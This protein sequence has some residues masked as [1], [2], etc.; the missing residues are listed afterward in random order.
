[1]NLNL[2]D[3]QWYNLLCGYQ[4]G[5]R[6]SNPEGP[7]YSENNTLLYPVSTKTGVIGIMGAGE[8]FKIDNPYIRVAFQARYINI[9]YNGFSVA[10]Q[11]NTSQLSLVGIEPGHF[12]TVGGP[13][14]SAEVRY[15]ESGGV[16]HVLGK[17][18]E[19]RQ[20]IYSSM[21]AVVYDDN[22]KIYSTGYKGTDL[23]EVLFYLVFKRS[24]LTQ[25][26]YKLNIE[27]TTPTDLNGT[28][29]FQVVIDKDEEG[30]ETERIL[31][32]YPTDNEQVVNLT[33]KETKPVQIVKP[34]GPILTLG[35]PS[36]SSSTKLDTGAYFS[37]TWCEVGKDGDLSLSIINPPN[38]ELKYIK[39][40]LDIPD[41]TGA[42]VFEE[43]SGLT[44]WSLQG[45]DSYSNI[46]HS[47]TLQIIGEAD[48]TASQ[49]NSPNVLRFSILEGK[50]GYSQIKLNPSYVA[51]DSYPFSFKT[52][53]MLGVEFGAG[54]AGQIK[55]NT[56]TR[57]GVTPNGKDYE[58]VITTLEGSALPPGEIVRVPVDTVEGEGEIY[59]T[60]EQDV[61]ISFGPGNV[62]IVHLYPGINKVKF[63]IP[64][65]RAPDDP[66][67]ED[68]T[69]KVQQ[70][71]DE[72]YILIEGG[73]SWSI[74]PKTAAKEEVQHLVKFDQKLLE[75]INLKDFA[76]YDLFHPQEPVNLDA[77][78]DE[79][80]VVDFMSYQKQTTNTK[81]TEHI[82]TLVAEDFSTNYT[83]I[84][85]EDGKLNRVEAYR[86]D[87]FSLLNNQS[88]EIETEDKSEGLSVED[89]FEYE[90][91]KGG[92]T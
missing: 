51:F 14:S 32:I 28:T 24:N 11:Y 44:S 22:T 84:K 6:L 77:L 25:K 76:A 41:P 21:E 71:K 43:V 92:T 88:V 15:A 64:T 13:S 49:T 38:P 50:E 81:E 90:L 3:N 34:Q 65:L 59:S 12:G 60:E 37:T 53:P 79:F 33:T 36:P 62:Q 55:E 56:T 89:I 87:D 69:L 42:F 46:T 58:I 4:A 83:E 63:W 7:E 20:W 85:I 73:F 40:I 19:P 91:I 66:E 86:V 5:M 45:K 48:F 29:L 54:G 1:M 26:L 35:N 82:D 17:K 70:V 18:N 74:I 61:L 10:I 8:P 39:I 57:P 75:K 16:I 78:I 72:G 67:F 68:Y 30:N 47:H 23:G 9:L 80:S 52:T 31:F 27:T 2:T